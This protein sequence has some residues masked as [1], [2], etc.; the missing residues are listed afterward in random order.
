MSLYAVPR[1]SERLTSF[2]AMLVSRTEE[3]EVGKLSAFFLEVDFTM[4]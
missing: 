3:V 1:L 4:R 2:L